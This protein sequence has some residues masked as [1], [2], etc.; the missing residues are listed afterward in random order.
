MGPR[1]A[2]N[3][4]LDQSV[5]ELAAGL[6]RWGGTGIAQRIEL[7]DRLAADT[8]AAS[9]DL[10]AASCLGKG[11]DPHSSTAGEEWLGGPATV[12]RHIRL[13]RGSLQH[14]ARTGRPPIEARQ[15]EEREGTAVARVF[16]QGLQDRLLLGGFQAEVWMEA[17]VGVEET[18]ATSARAYL[19]TEEHG[20]GVCAVLGAGNVSGIG[21]QDTLTKVFQENRVCALKLNPVNEY[22]EPSYRRAFA[23]L[24]EVGALRLLCGDHELGEA[25]VHHPGVTEVHMTGSDAVHDAIVWGPLDVREANRAAGRKLL[26][27]P[28]TSELGCVTPVMVVPGRWSEPDLHRQARNVASMV[29]NNASFNCNAAKVLVTAEGWEQRGAFLEALRQALQQVPTRC[30]YYPGAGERQAGFLEAHEGSVCVGDPPPGHLP[31]ALATGLDPGNRADPA[32]T[33]EAWCGV[34][35]ETALPAGGPVE[36]LEA[37]PRFANEVLFGTLSCGLIAS[38]ASVREGAAAQALERAVGDLRYG[39]VALNHWPAIGYGLGVTP[40]GAYPG[41][42][43]EDVGSGRGMVHN[44]PMFARPAKGVVRG[45]FAP[46]MKPLWAA[47]HRRA[48]STAMALA[49]YEARPSPGTLLALAAQALR[50]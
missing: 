36:F 1:P 43:L 8:L 35:A 15:M 42:T 6:E 17:G 16:P 19:D 33:T 50:G 12:L 47:D 27:K 26:D 44:T 25:L 4:P 10:V 40:W 11:I 29:T 14:I 38:P 32:F 23:A 9:A 28:I 34:L 41:Q 3:A 37:A 45:P 48:R 18:V 31:W 21:L 46:L 24:I 20:G 5:S 7:L 2:Q 30:A 49:R 22:L 13:L 39:T